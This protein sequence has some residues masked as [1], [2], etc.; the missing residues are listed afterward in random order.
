M[1]IKVNYQKNVTTT[2]RM[3]TMYLTISKEKVTKLATIKEG[4]NVFK[5]DHKHFVFVLK[6]RDYSTT[7]QD[8][9]LT[10]FYTP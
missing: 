10:L 4:S 9:I 6:R 7:V 3:D 5:Q 1:V 2:K 8:E